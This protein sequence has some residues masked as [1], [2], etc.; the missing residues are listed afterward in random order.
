MN[1]SDP[2]PKSPAQLIA[3]IA[4]LEAR[5]QE[6]QVLLD[7]HHD[8]IAVFYPNGLFR[9]ANQAFASSIGRDV[10]EITG[11]TIHQ[12][13]GKA[14]AERRFAV[15][16]TAIERRECVTSE[17]RLP[18]NG[19]DH[20]LMTTARPILDNDG[21][22]VSVT[23]LS[24][25]ITELRQ[26]E[27]RLARMAQ[28]DELTDL[29]NRTLF[30]DRLLKAIMQARRWCTRAALLIVD[31]DGFGD[32][33]DTLGR[34]IGDLLLQITASR[35][36]ESV[37]ESDSVGRVGDDEFV[38]L[39]P[40]ADEETNAL[41]VADKIRRALNQPIELPERRSIRLSACVGIAIY[42][43]H[44]GDEFQL[45][46]RA[47]RALY[48]AKAEGRNKTCVFSPRKTEAQPLRA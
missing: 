43:D 3:R 23:C 17:V 39:L 16:R 30:N 25:D 28:Y 36:L 13:F 4:E 37:R 33:N 26:L 40:F 46:K 21:N 12:L 10:D 45:Y 8:A 22:V 9:Y 6:Q 35:I 18:R 42:P 20:F 7:E 47:D 2:S 29:P 1:A 24:R 32:I 14:D 34:P 19:G 15:V 44:G 5:A 11:R 41:V 48:E 27:E 38:V 31:I